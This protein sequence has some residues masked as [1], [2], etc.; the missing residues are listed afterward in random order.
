M[1]STRIQI[2]IIIII[3]IIIT[4]PGM[5]VPVIQSI[6]LLYWLSVGKKA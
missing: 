1:I 5:L 3:I 2:I 6:V 4:I